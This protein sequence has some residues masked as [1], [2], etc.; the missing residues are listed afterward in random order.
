MEGRAPRVV[1]TAVELSTLAAA[2]VGV[3]AVEVASV[4]SPQAATSKARAGSAM[5]ARRRVRIVCIGVPFDFCGS[6]LWSRVE[7]SVLRRRVGSRRRAEG[8]DMADDDRKRYWWN[9]N[10][11]PNKEAD[12]GRRMMLTIGLWLVVV[13]AILVIVVLVR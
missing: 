9:L 10:I 2:V 13:V 8:A 4:L 7:V 12:A 5:S 11:D 3:G 6:T 1:P